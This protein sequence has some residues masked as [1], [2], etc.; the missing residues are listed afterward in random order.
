[1]TGIRKYNDPILRKKCEKIEKV[2][3]EIKDLI[4]KMIKIVQENQG[5]G[6]AACQI[7]LAKRVIIVR[8]E[9]GYQAFINPEILWQ[10][11][12][13]EIMEE[14]CLSFPQMFLK[15]KRSKEVE[16]KALTKQGK[17]IHIKVQG[18]LARIFQ[19][20]IDHLNGILFIDHV[21]IGRKIWELIKFHI[22]IK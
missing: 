17:D 3:N 19:H 8:T 2:N 9:Q 5:V 1:M 20:E 14:G 16:I 18:I 7:G 11:R 12:E 4:E 6:L 21:G 10:S 13:K 22:R 15:I